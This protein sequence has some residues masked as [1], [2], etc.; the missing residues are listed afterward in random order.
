MAIQFIPIKSTRDK[1]E[2]IKETIDAN[3]PSLPLQDTG[4]KV[5]SNILQNKL[6]Q[7]QKEKPVKFVP[8]NR[9]MSRK[10]IANFGVSEKTN[11][12]QRKVIQDTT[13]KML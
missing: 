9:P 4:T 2:D 11:A 1:L 3:K 6:E 13:V 8:L 10:E 5:I 7:S 12:K